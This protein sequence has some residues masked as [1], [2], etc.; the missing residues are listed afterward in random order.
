M[1]TLLADRRATTMVAP[2][3]HLVLLHRS[4]V[5]AQAAAAARHVHASARGVHAVRP[6][7][8]LQPHARTSTGVVLV[9][10]AADFRPAHASLLAGSATHSS[11]VPSAHGVA[12]CATGATAAKHAGDVLTHMTAR[13][14]RSTALMKFVKTC[15]HIG[16]WTGTNTLTSAHPAYPM[17]AGVATRC[18]PCRL[19]TTWCATHQSC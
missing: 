16:C 9:R 17:L 11:A 5:R 2:D 4:H 14:S 18:V 7:V 3:E 10:M 15:T 13:S 8:A 6:A 12:G 1:Q 19:G